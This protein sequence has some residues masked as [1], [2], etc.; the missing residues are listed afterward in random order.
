[1]RIGLYGI[2]GV[3]NFGC[4]AIVR[5]ACQLIQRLYPEAQII[6][7][8]YSYDYDKEALQDLRRTVRE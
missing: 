6:Y 1:M 3:Y 4:E 8:T 7:F 2:L 5:G